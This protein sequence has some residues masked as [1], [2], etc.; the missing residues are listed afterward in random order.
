MKYCPYCGAALVG[1]AVSFCAECG[2]ALP[3]P[4]KTA[5]P[6][7]EAPPRPAPV[8][9]P[10]PPVKKPGRPAPSPGKPA[11]P[12]RRPPSARTGGPYEPTR[13]PK[14]DPRDEGYDGYYNDVKPIDNGHIRDRSDPALTKRIIMVAA[15]AFLIVI[16][17]VILMQLL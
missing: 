10:P 9:R 12:S 2:R 11:S 3:S 4:K 5:E 15:G 1:G 7:R 6:V 8:R 13:R 16:L 14:P 17:A